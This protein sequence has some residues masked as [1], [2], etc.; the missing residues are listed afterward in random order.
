MTAGDF[1]K[2][3]SIYSRNA[4]KFHEIFYNGFHAI[5][6]VLTESKVKQC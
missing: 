1:E 6:H 5:N 2:V 3:I 4:E